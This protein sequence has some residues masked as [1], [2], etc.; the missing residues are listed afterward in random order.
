MRDCKIYYFLTD[1]TIIH[2]PRPLLGLSSHIYRV[3][4]LTGPAQ[5]VLSIRL[6]Q[7]SIKKVLSDRIYLLTGT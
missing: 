7:N 2:W 4:F 5:K 6:H 1:M 3:Y